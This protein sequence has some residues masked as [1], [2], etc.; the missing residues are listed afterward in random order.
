MARLAILFITV[1]VIGCTGRFVSSPAPQ[2]G[3]AFLVHRVRSAD[4][5]FPKILTWYTGTTLSQQ[6]VLRD[7]TYVLERELRV[8]DT[9][10]IPLEVVANDRPYGDDVQSTAAPAV[11]LLMEGPSEKK[12]GESRKDAKQLET[13]DD[14]S[15]PDPQ[16]VNAASSIAATPTTQDSSSRINELEREIREREV[17]LKKLKDPPT[18]TS[19]PV[20]DAAPTP[21]QE[22]LD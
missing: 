14:E 2:E 5:S 13:F 20:I 19:A 17:E 21:S 1:S 8:G 22:V 11:D 18:A 3:G 16:E 12:A 10:K 6:I 9:I 15:S 4:E 7:N